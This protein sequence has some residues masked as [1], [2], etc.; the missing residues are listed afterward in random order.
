MLLPD[1]E[2]SQEYSGIDKSVLEKIV[3][4]LVVVLGRKAPEL[5]S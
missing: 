1:Q 5:G 2:Q 3:P 4:P